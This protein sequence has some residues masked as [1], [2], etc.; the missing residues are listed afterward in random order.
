MFRPN[1]GTQVQAEVCNFVTGRLP[2][3]GYRMVQDKR[4]FYKCH[5]IFEMLV[6]S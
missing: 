4:D 3:T 5:Q 6:M 1:P 2:G